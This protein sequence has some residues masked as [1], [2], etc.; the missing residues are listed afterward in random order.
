M[1]LYDLFTFVCSV[2]LVP[3]ADN[4]LWSGHPP[5]CIFNLTEIENLYIV[6]SNLGYVDFGE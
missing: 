3:L 6:T 1:W 5:A 4:E 2:V